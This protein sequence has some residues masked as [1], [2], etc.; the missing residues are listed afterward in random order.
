MKTFR[1]TSLALLLLATLLPRSYGQQREI[2]VSA[3]HK[4]D[5]TYS[6]EV[7]TP[8]VAW[9]SKLPAGPIKSFF[10]PSV[11]YGRDMVELM[12]RLQ[13]EPTTVSIDREWDIN[14]WGI[15]DYYGHEYRGDRDDFQTVYSYVEKDLT[16][17]APF[18]VLVI[19]G[20]N[21]WS[22]MTRA[23]RDAIIRRVRQGAGLVLLHPFVG[24]VKGHPFKGDETAGDAR[25]WDI[26]PLIE[27]ADDTVNERGYPEINQDAVTKG[28]W[29]VAQEH[30]ITEA[31]PLELLPEG[32]VGGSFYKY[33]ANGD[34]LIKSGRYPIVAVKNYGEG[35]GGAFAYVEEG[36]TPQS[37]DPGGTKSY[38]DYWEY[39]IALLAR[40]ILWSTGR[41]VGVHISAL[42][43]GPSAL[44]LALVSNAPRRV[45]I[46]VAGKNEFVQALGSRRVSQQLAVGNNVIEIQSASLR[47]ANGWPGGR[48][49]SNVIIRD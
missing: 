38:W 12:E 9:A 46:E 44:K 22:R 4:N 24:D 10:I 14:C 26:S 13:L 16:G 45:E 7:V 8:H 15:G 35:R 19:P 32:N 20:L 40:A 49:I 11:E 43:A 33:R 3:F 18:E 31:L 28:K 21:G 29:E 36:F 34:V 17:P 30:F 23:T 6:T 37:G 42:T 1:S 5:I 2:G 25:I 47:P 39:Q 41:D 48:Q 27:V